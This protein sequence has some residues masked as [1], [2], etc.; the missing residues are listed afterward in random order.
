MVRFISLTSR[1]RLSGYE[2]LHNTTGQT[3][4][5]QETG[6]KNTM[7]SM[8][9]AKSAIESLYRIFE[10]YPLR[11]KIP[12]C[13][14]CISETD[15]Q[16]LH[17]RPL[18]KLTSED[19]DHYVWHAIHLWGDFQDFKHFLPRLFE[20]EAFDEVPWNPEILFGRLRSASWE[21][22]P[23]SEKTA[24]QTLFETLWN[25]VLTGHSTRFDVDTLLC[26]LGCA[27]DRI[28]PYLE[29]WLNV[30][31]PLA[32]KSL[33]EFVRQNIYGI[34]KKGKLQNSF[35]E[36]APMQK[37]VAWLKSDSTLKTLEALLNQQS[38]PNEEL[39]NS[40][41]WLRDAFGRMT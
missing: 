4:Q 35:W 27:M 41:Q 12:G 20:L 25:D 30:R 23:E 36:Q 28:E 11:A 31:T 2:R 37:V 8:E 32:W 6:R 15:E 39:Y 38:V 16:R 21:T 29:Q 34:Q 1:G 14:D 9:T 22:W 40:W 26:G 24:L 3:G 18:R 13:D 33:E 7:P 17:N 10:R 19:L 5:A